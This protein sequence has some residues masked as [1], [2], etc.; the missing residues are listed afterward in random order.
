MVFL[1]VN[2][3]LILISSREG[4]EGHLFQI[5]ANRRGT[6]LRRGTFFKGRCLFKDLCLSDPHSFLSVKILNVI[7]HR[8]YHSFIRK[9][10]KTENK[11]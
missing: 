4:R 5:L 1:M 7:E 3:K 2:S 9:K 6:Y 11:H 10:E 8:V